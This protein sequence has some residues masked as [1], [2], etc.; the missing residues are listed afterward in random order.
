MSGCRSSTGFY[1]ERTYA[2][3]N[4]CRHNG[5]ALAGT[6]MF[7]LIV[8]IM[9]LGVTRQIGTYLRMEKNFQSQRLYNDIALR[10]L[11]WGLTLLETGKPSTNPYSC[12]MQVGRDSLQ[13]YVVTFEEIPPDSNNYKVITRPADSGDSFLPEVP[14]TFA[15]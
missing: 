4:R 5:H 11:S 3:K 13:T 6:I 7:L 8:M 9:W 15:P 12:R 10:A 14:D 1:V 2:M